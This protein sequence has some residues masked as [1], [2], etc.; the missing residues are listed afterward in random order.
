MRE[1]GEEEGLLMESWPND[2][3]D[4]ILASALRAMAFGRPVDT[5]PDGT[6]V[7][8]R[9]DP[10]VGIYKLEQGCIEVD[11][12]EEADSDSDEDEV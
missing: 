6:F 1:L 7:V 2:P 4:G 3:E 8:N 5:Y 12:W 11:V 9:G 10:F